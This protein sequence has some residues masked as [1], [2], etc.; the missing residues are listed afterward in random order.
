MALSKICADLE[1]HCREGAQR[2]DISEMLT[3]LQQ[4]QQTARRELLDLI[5]A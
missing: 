4:A 3:S 2:Q 5:Q 1:K